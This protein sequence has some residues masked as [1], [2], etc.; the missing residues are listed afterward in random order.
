M[1][2]S[3]HRT[4]SFWK[5]RDDTKAIFVIFLLNADCYPPCIGEIN[6]TI[7]IIADFSN[8]LFNFLHDPDGGF[9]EF[10]PYDS[11]DSRRLSTQ[12]FVDKLIR[13]FDT[14][15]CTNFRKVLIK[16]PNAHVPEDTVDDLLLA[17]SDMP[18]DCMSPPAIGKPSLFFLKI[19]MVSPTI[20]RR[21]NLRTVNRLLIARNEIIAIGL[22]R[23]R[24]VS[25]CALR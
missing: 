6:A 11:F 1:E 25:R 3:S 24:R 15:K 23:V 18:F 8:N 2:C 17:L 19:N 12:S 4:W 7:F 21:N 14:A 13:F 5:C 20:C 10:T 22:R 9:A 16:A